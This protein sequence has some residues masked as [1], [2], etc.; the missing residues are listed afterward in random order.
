MLQLNKDKTELFVF[1]SNQHVKK[2]KNLR[3]NVGSGYINSSTSVR[4]LG[5]ILDTLQE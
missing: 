3:I 4:S 1:S 2:T 5:L